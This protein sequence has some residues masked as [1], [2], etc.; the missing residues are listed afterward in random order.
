MYKVR[1]KEGEVRDHAKKSAIENGRINLGHQRIKRRLDEQLENLLI[2]VTNKRAEIEELQEK[3]VRVRPGAHAQCLAFHCADV[4]GPCPVM[5]SKYLSLGIMVGLVV[6]PLSSRVVLIGGTVCSALVSSIDRM[7]R[8]DQEILAK[9]EET[10][11]LEA[12]LVDILV[13]QQKTLL[14]LLHEADEAEAG[15]GGGESSGGVASRGV[16]TTEGAQRTA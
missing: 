7:K 16:A 8:V 12:G 14:Q 11:G 9:N 10:K 1:A 13:D 15:G 2:Q 3:Y 4:C 5:L 6:L